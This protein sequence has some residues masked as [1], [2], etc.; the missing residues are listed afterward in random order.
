MT[1]ARNRSQAPAGAPGAQPAVTGK[2]GVGVGDGGTGVG[3]K[4]GDGGMGV[5]VGVGVGPIVGV[6]Q[7]VSRNNPS[8]AM[9]LKR[10]TKSWVRAINNPFTTFSGALCP[11]VRFCQGE[12]G[13][14]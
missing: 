2:A 14:K 4:V 8:K 3:V 12:V 10:R 13:V 6:A 11:V 9:E 7:P 5:R 1:P